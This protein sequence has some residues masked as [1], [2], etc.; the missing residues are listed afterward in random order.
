MTNF[1][2]AAL[3]IDK[4][5][6]ASYGFASCN[7][8]T[9]IDRKPLWK[10]EIFLPFSF[11]RLALKSIRTKRFRKKFSTV[12]LGKMLK[13]SKF[14][15]VET[16]RNRPI[17]RF[18]SEFSTVSTKFPQA[19]CR[20][21][22]LSSAGAFL[23]IPCRNFF[24]HNNHVSLPHCAK[25]NEKFSFFVRFLLTDCSYYTTE[26]RRYSDIKSVI[27]SLTSKEKERRI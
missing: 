19:D 17:M 21:Y 20:K 12:I 4:D 24:R 14:S 8:T 10:E 1:V 26:I 15:T 16:R 22:T 5:S 6:L 25:N 9:A 23:S 13:T 2:K 3:P 18:S 27:F 7:R 11:S